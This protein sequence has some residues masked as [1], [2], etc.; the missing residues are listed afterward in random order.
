MHSNKNKLPKLV[1]QVPST[2]LYRKTLKELIEKGEIRTAT[3]CRLAAEGSCCRIEIVNARVNQIDS[4]YKRGLDLSIAKRIRGRQAKKSHMRTRCIPLNISLYAWLLDNLD[5]KQTYIIPRIKGDFN[6][7]FNERHLNNLFEKNNLPFTIHQL[8]HYFKSRVWEY[9][10]KDRRPDIGVIKEMMGHKKTVHEAYGNY[11]WEYKL[12]IVDKVFATDQSNKGFNMG[13]LQETIANGIVKGL[14]QVDIERNSRLFITDWIG[15][16]M[17]QFQP[18]DLYEAIIND[19]DL[20]AKLSSDLRFQSL[21]NKECFN[22]IDADAILQS[23]RQNNLDLY[24]TIIN[25]PN[26]LFWIR[27]QINNIKNISALSQ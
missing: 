19:D 21:Q 18:S 14:T 22:R 27:K 1:K 11:S 16:V 20:W 6:K 3:V 12:E 4:K 13:S 10:I 24:S 15:K 23:I 7:P 25:T 17:K 2:A 9:M 26:G 5:L 8:R